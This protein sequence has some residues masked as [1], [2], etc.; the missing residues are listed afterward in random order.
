MV[1]LLH[2]RREYRTYVKVMALYGNVGEFKE[3][4][5][6]WTQYVE[7][8]DQYFLA[9]EITD[10]D[11]QRAIL[12]SV[13]GS[14]TYSLLRDILQPKKPAQTEIKNI[15]EELKKHY[16]P[17]PSEIVERFKFHSRL[18]KEGESVATFVAG[19]RNLSEHCNFRESLEDM[20]RDRL[21]CGINN[22]QI[23]R[24][25]LAETELTYQKAVELALA[26]ESA[27]KN[28]G[29]LHVSKTNANP[30]T[31]TE[32]ID[33]VTHGKQASMW[34]KNQDCYRCGGN[35][36]PSA[37]KFKDAKCYNCQKKGHTAKKCRSR[38]KDEDRRQTG[39]DDRRFRKTSNYFL[40]APNAE[41]EAYTMYHVTGEKNK[42]ITIDIDLCGKP[43]TMELDTGASK[44]ILNQRTYSELRGKLGPL[45][46]PTAILST[47][48]GEQIPI[49]GIVSVPVKYGNQEVEL[50]ALVIRGQGPN[51]FGRDWLRIIK[52]NWDQVFKVEEQQQVHNPRLQQVLEENQ[53][54]FKEELGTLNGMEAKIYVD[55]K[56]SPRYLKA[57]PVPY[58]LKKRVEDELERLEKEGIVSQVEFSEWAAPI[59]PVV[60]ANGAVRICGDYKCTVNQVSKLDN[61]P[62]PKTEDLLA[63]VGGGEKFTKLDMSQA[64]QQLKLD[65]DSK[66]Y[67]TVNTHKG[68][69][70]YNRL[71]FG[72]SSAPGIFQ[73]AMENLLQG[74]PHVIVRIDDILVSGKNETAH[75]ENLRAVLTKLS[76]AGLRLREEKCCFMQ[77]EVIYCGY[78]INGEGIHPVAAKI[79]AIK[80]APTPKDVSQL[81]AFLGMLNYYHRFLPD[82]ATVLEPLHELLRKGTAW[83]W[84]SE[85]QEAFESAKEL[86]QSAK[87]LVHF[88]PDLELIIASDASNYGIGAVLSHKMPDGTER[89]IGYVS[90]SLNSA[91]RNYST[92]EKEALAIIV[93]VKK[94]HQFLYGHRFTIKTDHKP[95][96]GLLRENKGISSQASSRVQ[97]WALTLVAY[98]YKI[99]YK[100]GTANGNADALS[101]LPLPEMPVTTPIPGDTIMLMEHL[102]GTPLHSSNIRDWTRRDPVL[103]KVYQYT[104]GNWPST[105][106]SEEVRPYF[107]RRTEISVED[108]CLLWGSRVIVP[109]K[110]RAKAMMALHEAHPGVSRTKALA[111]SYI[112][113]PQLDGEIEQQVKNCEKCQQNQKAPAEAPLHPWEWPGQPWTR[114]H[115]DYAG[116]YKGE[117]FFVL[118]DAHSKWLEVHLMKSTTSTATIEKLREI[119]A[120]HGLPRTVVSDNGPNFSSRE[121]EVFMSQN[122][123]KHIKVSPYHP[124]SN[125]QAERAVRIFKEGMEKM[126]KGSLKTKLS[127]FLLKYRITPHSTTGVPPAQ[128]LMNRQLH[129]QLDLVRPKISDRVMAKQT[130]QKSAHNYHA[131]DREIQVDDPVYAKDFRH[132]KTWISGTVV[133]KTGPVSAQVLLNNGKVIRRHQDHLRIRTDPD[134]NQPANIE[135]QDTIPLPEIVETPLR[136]P[137]L[138][139]PPVEPL[140]PPEPVRPPVGSMAPRRCSTRKRQTPRHLADYQLT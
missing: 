35:H 32:Q 30:G 113:W 31:P 124:A 85:Q 133:E 17:R 74:I 54:V 41:E 40:H 111:R 3:S 33:K 81:R 13:C 105:C 56:S 25:L 115:V 98:E 62:I 15:I 1:K 95:L 68:L 80:N 90:R 2:W 10:E 78:V 135:S 64:Y 37:C 100:A 43:Q 61:Y 51:L 4:E 7:R 73:R 55:E 9:N 131:R 65:Q 22:H 88:N 6:S 42:A 57:R 24:R 108:G 8:L 59:V 110:G 66:K 94:F 130:L 87:L 109:Q 63:T 20:L 106:P 75:L 18:R 46:K 93:G 21:V 97:R 119:F 49:A 89:P 127:R 84:N 67:T 134:P 103:E 70:Q 102:E 112:W 16:N 26:M 122:G 123:I 116:P 5:K 50:S 71:P 36:E 91:E 104:L 107:N 128:L 138:V 129:T 58:A 48:T 118:V 139:G 117:M 44:T 137:E 101:R 83:K 29:D 140:R 34:K 96:E 69:F 11:K 92:I 121:F 76:Q 114:L 14:K 136:P 12:L 39:K 99:Q 120:T 126:E 82:V 28:V 72:I 53:D 47:Y 45:K 60:K 27:S 86:L 77:T 132:P 52:V 38:K 79:D 23:Q 19:L 125:G